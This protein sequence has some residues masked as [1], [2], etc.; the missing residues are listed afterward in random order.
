MVSLLNVERR[1]YGL[2]YSKQSGCETQ[3]VRTLI[4]T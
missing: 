4:K 2:I 3:Q 1:H